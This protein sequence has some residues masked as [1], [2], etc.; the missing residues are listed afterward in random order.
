LENASTAATKSKKSRG[1]SRKKTLK[2]T[3]FK[4]SITLL[5]GFGRFFFFKLGVFLRGTQIYN[6]FLQILH[7]NTHKSSGMSRPSLASPK[8]TV[9][10]EKKL[11]TIP[12]KES[13]LIPLVK[14]QRPEYKIPQ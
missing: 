8:K 7:K 12:A 2:I 13:A 14:Y 10:I 1:R 3:Y 9:K 4:T 11:P 5:T 6:Q